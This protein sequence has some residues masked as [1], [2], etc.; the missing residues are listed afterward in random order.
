MPIA[1]VTT[2]QIP[3]RQQDRQASIQMPRFD[4]SVMS[5]PE[6]LARVMNEFSNKAQ[7]AII[8]YSLSEI[9]QIN[10]V[11]SGQIVLNLAR[12]RSFRVVVDADINSIDVQNDSPGIS[13]CVLFENTGVLSR[14]VTGWPTQTFALPEA[15]DFDMAATEK[16]TI[17]FLIGVE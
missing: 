13:F 14:N 6:E 9:I 16:V 11:S 12:G 1:E 3:G 7:E 17:C 10:E 8:N 4:M 15:L 5:D 2:F